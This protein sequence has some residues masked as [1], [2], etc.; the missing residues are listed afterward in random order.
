MPDLG[1]IARLN[2]RAVWASEARGFTPWLAENL[3]KLG[4][5]LGLELELDGTEHCVGDFSID[6]LARDLGRD[7]LVV[8]EN[9]LEA[10]DH[11]HLGQALTYAA[12]VDAG[13][14]V[15]I[16]PEFR[17]EHR[18]AIDWLNRSHGTGTEFFAVAVEI[19]QI[20]DSKPAVNFR[21]VAAPNEWFRKGKAGTEEPTGKR[22]A[23]Q[24]FFQ[25]LIDRLRE[26]HRFTNARA[27]QP[28]NWYSFRSGTAGYSYSVSF[29]TGRRLRAEV[30]IDGGDADANEAALQRL[31]ADHADIERQF[32]EPLTWELL[33]TK[34]A[35]RVCV[36]R[37]ASIEDAQADLDRHLEWA[38]QKLLKLKE[39]FGPRLV[40]FSVA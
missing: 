23:Y 17:E 39:V 26:E 11:G 12:G 20:D 30:Y 27:G 35:C 22:L 34:R 36:Y 16:S 18:Q 3:E 19:L 37:E 5:L 25:R 15:W 32:G 7:R 8:I 13:V 31:Q 2:P 21:L 6:I 10:T 38:I 33:E 4:A 14:V 9:Q 28:Q 1:R 29:S 24:Q 40:P